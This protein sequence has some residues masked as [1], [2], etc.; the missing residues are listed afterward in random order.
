MKLW[1]GLE[2]I[3]EMAGCDYDMNITDG[4]LSILDLSDAKIVEGGSDY[5]EAVIP[6]MIIWE[7][8]LFMDAMV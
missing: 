4:K 7:I 6:L 8:M 2:F 1:Y 5:W 3:R